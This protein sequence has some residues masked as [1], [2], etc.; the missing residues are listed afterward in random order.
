MHVEPVRPRAGERGCGGS[1]ACRR[2]RSGCRNKRK[3]APHT[4]ELFHDHAVEPRPPAARV[5]AAH[6]QGR[7]ADPGFRHTPAV[8]SRRRHCRRLL[9]QG[10]HACKGVLRTRRACSPLT[11]RS[12]LT[13][14]SHILMKPGSWPLLSSSAAR[15]CVPIS[16]SR[17]MP[18]QM[19]GLL[20][21]LWPRSAGGAKQP[22][23]TTGGRKIPRQKGSRSAGAVRRRRMHS[24]QRPQRAAARPGPPVCAT[25]S[26]LPVG[27]PSA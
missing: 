22:N 16:H 24:H 4:V 8:C 7:A 6:L 14:Q 2:R 26:T 17:S 20:R 21:I 13:R 12:W 19:T 9:R 10:C 18:I 1:A 23:Q 27:R 11:G 5:V 15:S 3:A 25:F